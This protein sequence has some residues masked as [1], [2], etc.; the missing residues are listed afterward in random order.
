MKVANGNA[1]KRLSESE[2]VSAALVLA[3]PFGIFAVALGCSFLI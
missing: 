3:L 1:P 2:W